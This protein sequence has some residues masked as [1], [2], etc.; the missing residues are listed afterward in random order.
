M[1]LVPHNHHGGLFVK[2]PLDSVADCLVRW[3]NEDKVSRFT[4][5]VR[6]RLPLER[7]WALIAERNWNPDRAIL[8]PLAGGWTAFFDNHSHEYTPAAEQYI[9][10]QRLNA[11]TCW[12]FYDDRDGSEHRGS[13]QFVYSALGGADRQRSVMVTYEGGWTFAEHGERLPFERTD[14]YALPR[15][16]DRLNADTLR[17]YGEALGLRFS[18]PA[19]YGDDVVLLKWC[20]KPPA[21]T[22]S[23]LQKLLRIFGRPKLTAGRF[24][25]GP[26]Q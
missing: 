16:R 7:A 2:A 1:S 6:H 19:A 23:S 4:T 8:V 5:A 14:F 22:A 25:G 17:A 13:A 24:D 26:P 3:G 9:L 20:D 12:F 18:D 10:G 11:Q 21:S 15:K